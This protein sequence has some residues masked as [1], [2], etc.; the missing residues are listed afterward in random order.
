MRSVGD[1]LAAVLRVAQPV[2]PLD[3]ILTDAVGCILAEPLIAPADVPGGNRAAC[4][5]YALASADLAH[6]SV[7]EPVTLRVVDEVSAATS[8][9]ARIVSG[10][11]V[12]VA[13]GVRVPHGADAVVPLE[14]SDRGEA[15]VRI[16]YP[17]RPG[18]NVIPHGSAATAGSVA[19]EAGTR[20]GARQIAL[21]ASL[22]FSRVTVHP[23]P[24]VVILTVGD[25]LHSANRSRRASEGRDLPIFDANGPALRV[26]VQDAGATAIQVGPLSDD[27]ATLREALEDQLVRADLV[28]TTGGLSDG[29]RDT[30]RD[31]LSPLGT[32]RFDRVSMSPGRLHGVGMLGTED[33]AVPIFALPGHPVAALV[34]FEVF[35][36]PALRTIAGYNDIYRP[37]L[38]A[39]AATS[40]QVDSH[41][42]QF[43]PAT[44]TG[45]PDAGYE[46]TPVA[47]PDQ[48]S[49][50]S[51]SALS[52]ANALV[53]VPEDVTTVAR[54][55]SLHCLVLEG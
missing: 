32:V 51:I 5:G 24:R 42:R 47:E 3:V 31:V 26:A 37:S 16:A 1:H 52:A 10:Q 9:P 20:M 4:D 8:E 21:A 12:K 22:G 11:S 53:V 43:V 23:R 44:I 49:S 36:R 6:A 34:A 50:L 15:K 35:V 45:T 46:V 28:V 27:R 30:L 19:I 41:E 17:P 54:G 14:Y 40:W 39:R 33:W 48:L 55:T 25:E 18:D 13:S 2:R 29:P 38:S 7:S